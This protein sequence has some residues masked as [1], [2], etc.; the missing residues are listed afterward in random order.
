M[1]PH[2]WPKNFA[3]TPY[4]STPFAILASAISPPIL[5]WFWRELKHPQMDV[6]QGKNPKHTTA[7]VSR[8]LLWQHGFGESAHLTA[9]SCFGRVRSRAGLKGLASF[10][11]V[12][13]KKNNY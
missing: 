11:C 13:E 9:R 10:Y 2:I 8:L 6:Q 12:A 4:M 7:M 1:Y 3:Y 5:F